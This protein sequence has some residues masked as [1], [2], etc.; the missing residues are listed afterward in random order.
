MVG[1]AEKSDTS[2]PE[3]TV[4]F[5]PRGGFRETDLGG[6]AQMEARLED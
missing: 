5:G 3:K 2:R 1:V 6:C 4:G